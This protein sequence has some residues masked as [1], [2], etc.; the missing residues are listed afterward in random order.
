MEK[1]V[2][3]LEEVV[4][5]VRQTSFQKV[6]GTV[7]Y[8]DRLLEAKNALTGLLLL[9]QNPTSIDSVIQSLDALL[10]KGVSFI[11]F[12]INPE[13]P[14]ETSVSYLMFPLDPGESTRTGVFLERIIAT[15]NEA[16]DKD[17]NARNLMSTLRKQ[18]RF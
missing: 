3:A 14:T 4:D 5:F 18:F 8:D 17:F 12:P 11:M 15:V 6:D 9:E 16:T 1:P 7:V 2:I 10:R 13:T